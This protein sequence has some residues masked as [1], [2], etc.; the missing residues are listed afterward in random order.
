M[1]AMGPVRS[2][3]FFHVMCHVIGRGTNVAPFGFSHMVDHFFP[4]RSG[5]SPT[6]DGPCTAEFERIW[7]TSILSWLGNYPDVSQTFKTLISVSKNHQALRVVFVFHCWIV[8][9]RREF[10]C[11]EIF[12]SRR[13]CVSRVLLQRSWI[14]SWYAYGV[15]FW[16]ACLYTRDLCIRIY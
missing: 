16:F 3:E 15:F 11:M 9:T 2:L 7:W 14:A 10:F 1:R 6:R 4:E 8:S 5:S 12:G 13:I